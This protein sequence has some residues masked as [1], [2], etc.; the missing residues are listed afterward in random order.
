MRF[1]NAAYNEKC[2][3]QRFVGQRFC[4]FK[5]LNK[6]GIFQETGITGIESWDL[7]ML[8]MSMYHGQKQLFC[9]TPTLKSD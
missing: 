5:T 4:N 7:D 9:H 1:G 2:Q 6:I 8:M 3:G